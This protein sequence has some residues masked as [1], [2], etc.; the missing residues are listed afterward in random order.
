MTPNSLWHIR[1]ISFSSYQLH[2]AA[3][4]A[5]LWVADWDQVHST[6]LSFS[7]DQKVPRTVLPMVED[8]TTGAKPNYRNTFKVSAYLMSTNIFHW[9]KQVICQ[10]HHQCMGKYTLLSPVRG[11][12]AL[13]SN[14]AKTGS[15]HW[16][17]P[18]WYFPLLLWKKRKLQEVV[19]SR[20]SAKIF[21]K[22]FPE[23]LRITKISFHL[24]PVGLTSWTSCR[25]TG[26]H[27]QKDPILGLMPCCHCLQ[28]FNTFWTRSSK[29]SFCTG[30]H[31]LCIQSCLFMLNV[32]AQK[33]RIHTQTADP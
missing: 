11:G 9:P 33:V 3:G 1:R 29:F 10:V 28:V 8:R 32:R 5:L 6:F 21:W 12:G 23:V 31:K 18:F 30:P 22:L 13:L 15:Y 16:H 27:I 20:I 19:I 17:L 25:S 14:M 24:L 4:I 2:R 26:P 7:L